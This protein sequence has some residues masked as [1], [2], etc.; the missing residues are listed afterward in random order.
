MDGTREDLMADRIAN[1]LGS[2][3]PIATE[4]VSKDGVV[5]FSLSAHGA[6]APRI[7]FL[8]VVCTLDD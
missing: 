6:D 7:R 5:R 8:L 1:M 2:T 4:I 3:H